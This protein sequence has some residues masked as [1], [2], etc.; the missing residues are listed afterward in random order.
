[1]TTYLCPEAFGAL[2]KIKDSKKIILP[3]PAE[4][5]GYWWWITNLSIE[6]E[7]KERYP[8]T[9]LTPTFQHLKVTPLKTTELN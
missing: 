5:Y 4:N 9:P 1:M 2:P 7:R 8:I 6:K 3:T